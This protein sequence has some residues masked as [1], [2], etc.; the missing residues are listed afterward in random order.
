MKITPLIAITLACFMLIS[1]GVKKDLRLPK[2]TKEQTV[3]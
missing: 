2:D 1:C 3:F